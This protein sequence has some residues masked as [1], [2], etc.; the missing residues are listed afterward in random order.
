MKRLSSPRRLLIVLGIVVAAGVGA[1]VWAVTRSAGPASPLDATTALTCPA[2][3]ARDCTGP[4]TLRWSLPLPAIQQGGG[5]QA[6][7]PQATIADGMLIY[8]QG[9][10]VEAID[11]ATGTLRWRA[12]LPGGTLWNVQYQPPVAAGSEVAVMATDGMQASIWRLGAAT[13]AVGPSLPVGPASTSLIMPAGDGVVVYRSGSNQI[14]NLNWATGAALW[15]SAAAVTAAYNHPAV[16]DGVL[17]N[18]DAEKGQGI[19]RLDL[20]TGRWLPDLPVPA[21]LPYVTQVYLAQ[22]SEA[23]IATDNATAVRVDP[24]TGRELWTVRGYD[25]AVAADMASSPPTAWYPEP[26]GLSLVTMN[27]ATGQQVAAFPLGSSRYQDYFGINASA[28]SPALVYGSDLVTYQPQDPGFTAPTQMEGL[29]LG[30]WRPAWVGPQMAGQPQMLAL[31]P[32]G[33]PVIIA[34]AC[35]PDGVQAST[36]SATRL[37]AVNAA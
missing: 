9:G 12:R 11:P 37:L 30:T 19:E 3:P 5:P 36:C 8:Q 16:I 28:Q 18:A 4:G 14:E 29:S 7:G 23:L 15:S 35:A 17:Y 27:L 33:P 21:G 34:E 24:A 31:T 6:S 13:G 32:S 22:G 26:A 25:S 1:T 10:L 20:D 2:S